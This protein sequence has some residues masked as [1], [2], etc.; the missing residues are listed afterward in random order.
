MYQEFEDTKRL[1]PKDGKK[2]SDRSDRVC[3]TRVTYVT[4]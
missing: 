2:V 4:G 1:T 3:R